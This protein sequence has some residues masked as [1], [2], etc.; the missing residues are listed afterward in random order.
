MLSELDF[1]DSIDDN[2]CDVGIM[3]ETEQVAIHLAGKMELK[4]AIYCT[5]RLMAGWSDEQVVY[6]YEI[7]THIKHLYFGDWDITAAGE[8]FEAEQVHTGEQISPRT[9]VTLL[10]EL[11]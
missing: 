4:D 11:A 8:L 7:G 10:D 6:Y 5:T 2:P 1:L 9:L 3:L